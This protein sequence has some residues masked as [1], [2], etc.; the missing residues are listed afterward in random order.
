MITKELLS[1][2]IVLIVLDTALSSL[3][4]D[5]AGKKLTKIALVTTLRSR[6]TLNCLQYIIYE[7]PVIL[8]RNCPQSSTWSVRYIILYK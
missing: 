7:F 8:L 1:S 4:V 6:L 3:S 2:L 5:L